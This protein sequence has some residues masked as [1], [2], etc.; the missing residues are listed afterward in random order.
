[1][2]IPGGRQCTT[3][4]SAKSE[5]LVWFLPSSFSHDGPENQP[6]QHQVE[7]PAATV[8]CWELA[9]DAFNWYNKVAGLRKS[10]PREALQLLD[11]LL[12]EKWPELLKSNRSYSA[13]G[14]VCITV[15]SIW[16]Q[17]R[18]NAETLGEEIRKHAAARRAP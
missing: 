10:D 14:R 18:R 3:A 16:E 13:P 12:D 4:T 9:A 15:P 5:T 11:E 17:T 2:A 6:E 1:M 7:K 8:C